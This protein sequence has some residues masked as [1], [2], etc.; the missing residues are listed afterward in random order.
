MH[1]SAVVR[2]AS[3][4]L[5]FDDNTIFIPLKAFFSKILFNFAAYKY[6][7]G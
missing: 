3:F 2:S 4:L 1:F 5:F 7:K 6:K